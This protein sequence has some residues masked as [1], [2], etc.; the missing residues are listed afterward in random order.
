VFFED[1]ERRGAYCQGYTTFQIRLRRATGCHKTRHWQTD[2]DHRGGHRTVANKTI[3][4]ERRRESGCR[5]LR[6]KTE[7]ERRDA[8]RPDADIRFRFGRREET[9]HLKHEITNRRRAP[10]LRQKIRIRRI[11][12][13]GCHTTQRRQSDATPLDT[14]PATRRQASRRLLSRRQHKTTYQ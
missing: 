5:T 14:E 1:N 2:A 4:I 9:G 6:W 3:R 11:S 8:Y 13:S 10:R 12:V 7:G